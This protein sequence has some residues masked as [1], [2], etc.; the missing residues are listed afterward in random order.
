M[1]RLNPDI[2]TPNIVIDTICKYYGYKPEEI[3]AKSR[4]QEFVYVRNI[5]F[6]FLV[7]LGNKYD[8]TGRLLNRDHSTVIHSVNI[9]KE[10][11]DSDI[12]HKYFNR[13][14]R[15]VKRI[16]DILF[17]LQVEKTTKI[18][19]I[20]DFVDLLQIAINNTKNS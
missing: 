12:N 7:I 9:I 10:V 4:K 17:E 5:I 14:K 1:K 2:I 6:Y 19:F 18:T 15:D 20:T 8:Y 16:A 3:K 13:V 11:L